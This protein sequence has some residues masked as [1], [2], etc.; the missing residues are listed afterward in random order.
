MG[1]LLASG[2]LNPLNIFKHKIN[3]SELVTTDERPVGGPKPNHGVSQ[4][5]TLFIVVVLPLDVSVMSPC[6][7]GSRSSISLSPG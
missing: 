3:S 6:V 1:V 2:S 7:V 5:D 4:L